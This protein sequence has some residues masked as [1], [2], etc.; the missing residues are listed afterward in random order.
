[1]EHATRDDEREQYLEQDPLTAK[2]VTRKGGLILR[3]N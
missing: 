3:K 2:R 1:M